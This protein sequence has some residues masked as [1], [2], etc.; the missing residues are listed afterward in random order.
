MTDGDFYHEG[1]EEHKEKQG[2]DFLCLDLFLGQRGTNLL[3]TSMGLSV[4]NAAELSYAT[5]CVL[6]VLCGS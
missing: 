5:L 3:F 2:V 6:C 4:N 1:N